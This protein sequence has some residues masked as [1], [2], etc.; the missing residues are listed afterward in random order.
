MALGRVYPYRQTDDPPGRPGQGKDNGDA[1]SDRS[2][3]HGK[4]HA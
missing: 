3:H 2:I 4:G 1:Q